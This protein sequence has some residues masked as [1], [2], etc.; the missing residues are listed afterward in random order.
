MTDT[1]LARFHLEPDLRKS[2]EADQ[3]PF[4][5][6]IAAVLEKARF[7]V[8]YAH[9]GET[10]DDDGAWSLT[11]MKQPP[12]ARGLTFRRVYEYPFWQIDQ[13]AERWRWDVARADYDADSI[14][15]KEATRFFDFWRK[16]LY[17]DAAARTTKDGFIYVPLQGRLLQQRSF[18]KCSPLEMVEHCVAHAGNRGI[19]ATLHPKEVYSPQE[20]AALEELERRHERLTIRT[21]GMIP[22][23]Q[24]CDFVVTQNSGVAFCGYFFQKPALLF[25]EIDFHHIAIS[26]D[27]ARLADSFSAVAQHDPDMARYVW[28]FW[29]DQ[30]INAGREDAEAKIA[31]RLARFGWPM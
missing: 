30:C 3:H 8:E 21:G 14:D 19:V 29:Q 22:L 26:A 28:W 5:A 1:R 10:A 23:L 2:A 31:A 18:Q 27:M 11:H 13:T 6:K 16:R 20:I 25:A 24:H 7:R 17:Q 12:D 9:H 4:I 15:G